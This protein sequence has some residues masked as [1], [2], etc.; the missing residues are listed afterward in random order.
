[1][2]VEETSQEPTEPKRTEGKFLNS[3]ILARRTFIIAIIVYSFFL[4]Y[5]AIFTI[6]QRGPITAIVLNCLFILL[7]FSGLIVGIVSFRDGKNVFGIIGFILNLIYVATIPWTIW[8]FINL[9]IQL[10]K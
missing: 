1:M 4:I 7:A 8:Q 5:G 10:S 6:T 3:P 2:V 9:V